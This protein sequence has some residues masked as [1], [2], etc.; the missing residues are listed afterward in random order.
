MLGIG[1]DLRDLF[2]E[3][4]CNIRW[5]D[6]GKVSGLLCCVIFCIHRI[7][8]SPLLAGRGERVVVS[9]GYGA[10]DVLAVVVEGLRRFAKLEC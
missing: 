7:F 10:G 9:V 1:P 5:L 6:K 4:F 8:R 2:E 3:L